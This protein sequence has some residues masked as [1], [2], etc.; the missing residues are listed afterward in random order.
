MSG[1]GPRGVG[2]VSPRGVGGVRPRGVGGNESA[3]TEVA[4]V[5]EG[6]KLS[7]GTVEY[8]LDD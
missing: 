1:S 8:A 4:N 3:A 5:G 7:L 6:G 2:D